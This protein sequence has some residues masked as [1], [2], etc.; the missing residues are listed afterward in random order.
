MAAGARRATADLLRRGYAINFPQH[1]FGES[2]WHHLS[3]TQGAMIP[4]TWNCSRSFR[5][6]TRHWLRK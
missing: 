3:H 4:A 6:H 1:I 2:R 5:V